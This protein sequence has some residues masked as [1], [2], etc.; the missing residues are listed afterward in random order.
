MLR[1]VQQPSLRFR[2]P[3]AGAGRRPPTVAVVTLIALITGAWVQAA[4]PIVSG[5]AAPVAV[6]PASQSQVGTQTD[7]R[8]TGGKPSRPRPP[9]RPQWPPE[10]VE[11]EPPSEEPGR[12]PEEL[13][14]GTVAFTVDPTSASFRPVEASQAV[15]EAGPFVVQAT[16]PL[17]S[18]AILCEVTS[19]VNTAEGYTIG[20]ERVEY[21]PVGNGLGD[22][23][24]RA[25]PVNFTEP[26]P[27]L[28]GGVGTR[29]GPTGASRFVLRIYMD[30]TDPAGTYE[31]MIRFSYFAAP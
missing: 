20:P 11:P 19:L 25:Q 17:R 31:G 10:P 30:W 13:P 24:Q 14:P 26:V 4:P 27:V 22:A 8:P 6:G 16:C 18:W 12:S 2:K 21:V 3:G 7:R 28:S 1:Y 9:S 29:D 5:T 15:W 23:A